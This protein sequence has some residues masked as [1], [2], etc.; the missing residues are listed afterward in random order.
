MTPLVTPLILFGL[1]FLLAVVALSEDSRLRKTELKVA[2]L[3]KC[4][5]LLT[6]AVRQVRHGEPPVIPET[7]DDPEKTTQM[8]AE[9]LEAAK[10][11]GRPSR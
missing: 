9:E 4:V 8:S 5:E 11:K 1:V 7:T 3:E 10:R 2:V 6:A